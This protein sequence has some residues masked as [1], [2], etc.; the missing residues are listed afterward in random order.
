MDNKLKIVLIV[1][2]QIGIIVASFLIL[3]YIENEWL[4]LGNSIDQAGLNR[5]LTAS[6]ILEAHNDVFSYTNVLEENSIDK[7]RKN[8][9]DLRYGVHNEEM[10]LRPLPI[11]LVDYWNKVHDNF[12]VFEQNVKNLETSSDEKIPLLNRLDDSGKKLV[13]SSDVLVGKISEFLEK[14]DVLL[15]RLE[16][17]LL[18]INSIVHVMLV[19]LIFR[20]LNKEAQE[21]LRLEKFVTIG[22]LGASIA[23][24]LK[25][26]LTTIK[27]S[28]EILKI[29]K[30]NQKKFS[31]EKQYK[32]IDESTSRI[33]YLLKDISEFS[34]IRDLKKEKTSFLEIIQNSLYEVEIPSQIELILPK[35]D[36]EITVDKVKFQ[37]VI[38][39]ILKNAIDAIDEK[40]HI[41]I[42]IKKQLNSNM[43]TVEDSGKGFQLKESPEIFDPLYTTKITG[44]GLGL[45]SCKRIVEQH[46]GKITVLQNP[47]RFIISIPK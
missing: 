33:E 25:N 16:L 44:T 30:D 27:G 10:K 1:G 28:L 29:Q 22:K 11:E 18:G 7:L 9:E 15:I 42:S 43:I 36:F 21:K 41:K 5:Y 3:V 35:Q 23:H 46:K 40:G 24:D 4:I 20:I 19:I 37:T 31:D 47:T 26:P 13:E 38:T 14:I 45:A 34:Q 8:L 32:K 17:L 2:C 6:S 39:N 12:I